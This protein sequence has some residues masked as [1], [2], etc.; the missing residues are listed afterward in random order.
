MVSFADQIVVR[1]IDLPYLSV[2]LNSEPS[3]RAGGKRMGEWRGRRPPRL[4]VERERVPQRRPLRY[5]SAGCMCL[6]LESSDRWTQPSGKDQLEG[7][8]CRV[9]Y[10]TNRDTSG[11]YLKDTG[12]SLRAPLRD[13]GRGKVGCCV[14]RVGEAEMS[15]GGNGLVS[16][17][18]LRS[19][20]KM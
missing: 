20:A 14:C 18:T 10:A 3:P 2:D 12:G 15:G 5:T 13:R 17:G 9:G 19:S 4:L 8:E 1:S 7:G 11:R 6:Q 16:R